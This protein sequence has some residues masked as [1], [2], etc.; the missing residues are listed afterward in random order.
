MKSKK[1]LLFTTYYTP[2]I[3]GGGPIQSIKN[4]VENLS[5][6][7]TFNII[8]SDRDL[9]DRHPFENIQTNVWN[10][11]GKA[12]VKYLNANSFNLQLLIKMIKGMDYDVIYLNSFFS[13]KYSILPILINKLIGDP[14]KL[15]VLSP[16]GEFSEGALG[17]K[18][19]K[20]LIY[21][22][23][24]KILGIYKKVKWH[25][26]AE[27]EKKDIIKIF[28]E[29]SNVVVASN[30]T[31]NYRELKYIEEKSKFSGE[32]NIVFLSRIH[33]KKN[34]KKAIE[35]LNFVKGNVRLTIF[36]P[37][38]DD[39]YWNECSSEIKKLPLNIKVEYK[40]TIEHNEILNM[41]KNHHIFLLPTLGENF[42]HV[43]SEALVGGCPIIISDNTPWRNLNDEKVGFDIS[44]KDDYK[45][46]SAIQYFVDMKSDEYLIYSKNAFE[47]GI[48]M[49]NHEENI[50]L[51]YDI[52][53]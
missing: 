6:Q 5:D 49:S 22:R 33:P 30:L 17:L 45:Y 4:I 23:I 44:L 32:L 46:I 1:I 34:L 27:G 20:K 40:G 7:I 50:Q 53:Q 52:F 48:K 28:G 16:R 36:G 47:Y 3:K 18:R 26:T 31:A 19:I 25:A 21:L 2:G 13:F 43:I 39:S 51:T 29:Y 11:V 42:G 24:V 41:Y 37:I 14:N 10:R 35:Y 15:I 12:N 8:T 38:E 9:G